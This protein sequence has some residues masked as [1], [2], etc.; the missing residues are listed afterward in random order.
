MISH[1]CI[2]RACP[3][4]ARRWRA[5]T[6]SI[7]TRRAFRCSPR[8]A[9][10][11]RC[12]KRAC[13]PARSTRRS[14]ASCK[15]LLVTAIVLAAL[16]VLAGVILGQQVTGPVE[17][18]DAMRRS[19]SARAISRRRFRS[20]ARKEVGKL[21]RTME[22]MRNNL[23]DLTG[24]VAA[25][26]GRSAGRAQRHRRRRVR[27]RQVARHPL[28]ESAGGAAARRAGARSDRPL[29][30]RRAEAVR[31]R[32]ASGPAKRVAR[33]CGRALEGSA[34]ATERLQ[35]AR[36]RA[37]HDHHHQRRAGRRSAGAGHSRRDRARRRASRARF[38]A[39]EHLARVPHAARR[40]ARLDRVAARRPRHA[41]R[42]SSRRSWC[43]RWSAA[44]CG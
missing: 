26:R 24:D 11:L 7:C 15:R 8:P 41:C 37:A 22:D 1:G 39:R 16:A 12:S 29:L 30:R 36:R 10:R 31:S 19:G 2:R 33:S 27:G 17:H 44:R 6:S 5:S 42:A 35:S 20:A 32:T 14:A 23:V 3:T 21:A 38:G 9:R 43:C 40:A 18:A 25:S 4:A 28:S 34:Q 13:P